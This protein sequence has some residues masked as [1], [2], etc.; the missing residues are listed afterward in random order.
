MMDRV[1]AQEI[2]AANDYKDILKRRIRNGVSTS[3][4]IFVPKKYVGM[5]AIVIIYDKDMCQYCKG[6][7]TKKHSKDKVE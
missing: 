2:L 3:G 7:G 6:T 1:K 4:R 5:D